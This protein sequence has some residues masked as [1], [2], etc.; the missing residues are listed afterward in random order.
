MVVFA[1]GI[2]IPKAAQPLG[3]LVKIGGWVE[4]RGLVVVFPRD[5]L[6]ARTPLFT[7]PQKMSWRDSG[8]ESS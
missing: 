7:R 3:I 6:L 1:G 2:P 4:K 5:M 8:T